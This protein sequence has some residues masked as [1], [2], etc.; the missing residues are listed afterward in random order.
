M[1]SLQANNRPEISLLLSCSHPR[2][3]S[4]HADSIKE[5]C[6]NNID[7]NY[8]LRLAG[9]HGLIPL[10]FHRLNSICPEAIPGPILSR[11]KNHFNANLGY[12]RFLTGELLRLLNLFENHGI[13]AIPFKGPILASCV[14]GDLSLREFS[15]LDILIPEKDIL[16]AKELLLSQ[17]YLPIFQL[18]T[19]QETALIKSACEYNFRHERTRVNVEIHWK[20][21]PRELFLPLTLKD[22]WERVKTVSIFGEEVQILSPEDL[23]LILCVHGHKHCWE[24]LGWVCDL[25]CLIQLHQDMEWQLVIGEAYRCSSERM[26]FLGLYLARDLL[27]MDLPDYV[28][29]KVQSDSKVESL[30]WMVYKD[31]FSERNGSLGFLERSLFHLRSI[32]TFWKRVQYCYYQTIPP[33]LV[34]FEILKFPSS[35]FFLYY[36]F[37]PFRLLGKYSAGRC[38]HQ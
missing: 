27:D 38:I 2:I 16:R 33:S 10:L 3:D 29:Q 37:R 13:P 12:N 17:G 5:I 26:L 30:A 34:E 22:I 31:L 23:L 36:V 8:L 25:A 6:Q 28:W 1:N 35:L 19:V 14:Y 21:F 11:L 4:K 18:N 24:G 20:F 32:K 7:W 15:D 9:C